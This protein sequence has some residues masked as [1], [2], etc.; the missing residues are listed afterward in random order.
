MTD[1]LYRITIEVEK[2]LGMPGLLGPVPVAKITQQGRLY[3]GSDPSEQLERACA[4]LVADMRT[5]LQNAAGWTYTAYE[6]RGMARQ[7]DGAYRPVPDEGAELWSLFGQLPDQTW[8]WIEDVPTKEYGA[9]RIR[10]Q[11]SS[12]ARDQA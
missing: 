11:G 9:Q 4:G 1:L 2:P 6:V 10:R 12:V 8:E 5:K 3:H 7:E